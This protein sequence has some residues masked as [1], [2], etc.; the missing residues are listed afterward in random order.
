MTLQC[1]VPPSSAR[2][3]PQRRDSHTAFGLFAPKFLCILATADDR[4]S[5]AVRELEDLARQENNGSQ[6]RGIPA[7][8]ARPSDVSALADFAKNE[9][10]TVDLW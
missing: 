10:G 4:V 7:N 5:A 3:R 9:L 1:A 8:M 6:V 2:Q